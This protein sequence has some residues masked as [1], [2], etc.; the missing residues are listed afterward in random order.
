MD[1]TKFV[2]LVGKSQLPFIYCGERLNEEKKCQKIIKKTRAEGIV[3]GVIISNRLINEGLVITDKGIWFATG[4]CKTMII[5]RKTK[6][7]FSFEKYL[8][9]NVS[10]KKTL[11]G[12]L[13]VEF[14]LWNME[15]E[16]ST[17]FSFELIVDNVDNSTNLYA[18]GTED[19]LLAENK[20]FYNFLVEYNVNVEYFEKGFE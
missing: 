14:I 18:C 6:G 3:S 10:V 4:S 15:K 13:Q 20:R 16:K 8:L 19:F 5:I 1:T 12:N 11:L 9:H 2:E 7:S 17:D